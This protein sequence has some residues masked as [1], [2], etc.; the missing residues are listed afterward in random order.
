MVEWR[1]LCSDGDDMDFEIV[2][3]TARRKRRR[4]KEGRMKK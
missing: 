3:R 2:Y 4:R 1:G